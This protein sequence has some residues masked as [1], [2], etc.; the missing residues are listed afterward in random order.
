VIGIG[1]RF[2]LQAVDV[3]HPRLELEFLAVAAMFIGALAFDLDGGIPR[4]AP[5][6]WRRR[7]GSSAAIASGAAVLR[8]KP[9]RPPASRYRFLAAHVKL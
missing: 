2:E 6:R 5:A 7:S 4:A 3:H 8:S 1:R 9:P